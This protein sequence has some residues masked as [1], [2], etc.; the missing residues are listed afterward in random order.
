[1]ICR[2]SSTIHIMRALYYRFLNLIRTIYWHLTRP[3]IVGVRVFL[4][5]EGKVLLVRHT[6]ED[7]WYLPGGGA[8]RGESIEEAARREVREE[9]GAEIA[10][11]DLFGV[12]TD[13]KRYKTDH[14]VVF[15]S[16]N[17]ITG[18]GTSGEIAEA[19]WFELDRLPENVSPGQ[20]RRIEEYRSGKRHPRAGTW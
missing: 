20:R 13:L 6:Y 10:D 12:Y 3:L 8:Q 5:R 2:Q 17:F 11:L 18:E 1:M 15:Q 9:T 16:C 19:R 7:G 4:V 14:V